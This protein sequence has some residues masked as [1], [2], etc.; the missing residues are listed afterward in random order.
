MRRQ[1]GGRRQRDLR[2]RSRSGRRAAAGD[3]PRQPRGLCRDE[4]CPRSNR[5]RSGTELAQDNIAIVGYSPPATLTEYIIVVERGAF[6]A[7]VS[8]PMSVPKRSSTSSPPT[9]RSTC[10]TDRLVRQAPSALARATNPSP[11]ASFRRR[12]HAKRSTTPYRGSNT[13]IGR[14][15][16]AAVRYSCSRIP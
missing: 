14:P 3:T 11:T 5:Q 2:S 4:S 16:A 10:W 7:D 9:A 12:S 1:G 15:A 13:K 6:P 8:V